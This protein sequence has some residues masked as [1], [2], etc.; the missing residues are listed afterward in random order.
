MLE[1]FLPERTNIQGH[2][3][4]DQNINE[5]CDEPRFADNPTL[6]APVAGAYFDLRQAQ[7]C[8]WL[9]DRPLLL[10]F[11]G[12]ACANCKKMQNTVLKNG[13]VVQ[14]L[15]Q[16]YVVAVLYTDDKTELPQDEW[17]VSD[18]DSKVKKTLGQQNLDHLMM[19]YGVNSVPFFAIESDSDAEANITMG[20]TSDADDFLQFL[21]ENK[22]I[23]Q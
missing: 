19:R 17:Y 15:Q 10:Y 21:R 14:M 8:A 3:V 4:D 12:H 23:A 2:V 18:F 7:N 6:S 20:Y 1:G 9:Q 13:A 22:N 5:L 16:D 11:K